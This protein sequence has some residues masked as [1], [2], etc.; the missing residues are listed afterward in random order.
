MREEGVRLKGR[1]AI[2]TGPGQGG[3]R[4]AAMALAR[5]GAQVVLFGRDA[6]KLERVAGEISAFG[7]EALPVPG[8]VTSQPDRD[9]LVR[10]ALDRFGGIDILVNAAQSPEDRSCVLLEVDDET[11]ETLWA[12]GYLASLKLMRACHPHMKARGGGSIINFGS[13]SAM[14]PAMHGVYAGVKAALQTTGRAAALEWAGDGIR[15]NTVLPLVQSPAYDTFRS[16]YPAE[17]AGFEMQIPLGRVGEG[18]PDIGRPIVFLASADSAFITGSTLAL[19]G[20]HV[21]LR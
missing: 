15:V 17:A 5:E 3:G 21:F 11:I 19:D 14:S 18:E 8:D 10:A 4:G 6:A 9:R 16:L 20:G 12:S 1:V 13:G 2:V 7:G